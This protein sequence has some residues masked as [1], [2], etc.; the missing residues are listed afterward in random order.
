MKDFLTYIVLAIIYLSVKSTITL[1]FPMPDMLVLIAFH[2]ASRRPSA[3]G[4]LLV[5]SLGYMEDVFS[6]GIIG[7][8]SFAMGIT[9]MGVYIVAHRADFTETK[10]NAI[11]GVTITLAK[12]I[13]SFILLRAI[14]IDINAW[15]LLHLIPIA[16]LTGLFAP[17]FTA[18]FDRVDT[19]LYGRQRKELL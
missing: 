14:D 5:F 9:Y 8:S 2:I 15:F 16:L 18:I 19:L 12:G 7:V 4:A 17:V 6:G 3:G 1:S 13:L 11:A 10:I